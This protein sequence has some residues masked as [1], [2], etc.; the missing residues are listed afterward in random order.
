M[1]V[2]PLVTVPADPDQDVALALAET[3]YARLVSIAGWIGIKHD[4][5]E[6]HPID[7][8]EDDHELPAIAVFLGDV[9][10]P[11]VDHGPPQAPNATADVL[12]EVFVASSGKWAG[13]LRP[14]MTRARQG[15]L[16]NQTLRTDGL[17]PVRV[18]ENHAFA[19]SGKRRAVRGLITLTLRYSAYYEPVLPFTLERVDVRLPM[20][21][22]TPEVVAQLTPADCET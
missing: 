6:N 22:Q 10:E 19:T 7:P 4:N 12:I 2:D 14:L 8:L 3:V 17:N 21:D 11:F 9:D 16:R 1:A 5:I 15:L 18:T 20:P 13:K